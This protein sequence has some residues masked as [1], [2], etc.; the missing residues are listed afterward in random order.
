MLDSRFKTSDSDFLQS[1][2]MA[3]SRLILLTVVTTLVTALSPVPSSTALNCTNLGVAC[4]HGTFDQTVPGANCFA[5]TSVHCSDV[6]WNFPAAACS[7]PQQAGAAVW[8]GV[9]CDLAAAAA[10]D[11]L[12]AQNASSALQWDA[13]FLNLATDGK[14][15]QCSIAET[16]STSSYSLHNQLVHLTLNA[17]S[18][19]V[20]SSSPTNASYI[21]RFASR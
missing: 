20:R 15:V 12:N 16:S 18:G 3:T 6:P 10:C 4:Q 2:G 5:T 11:Q 7:C 14:P 8:S 21:E 17:Q 19:F 1:A 13:T 9:N